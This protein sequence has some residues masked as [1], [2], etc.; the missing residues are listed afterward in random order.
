MS[1][2]PQSD[3]LQVGVDVTEL[4]NLTPTDHHDLE[5]TETEVKNESTNPPHGNALT[6]DDQ[7][8]LLGLLIL[9]YFAFLIS[10][11]VLN[12]YRSFALLIMTLVVLAY[13]MYAH[14]RDRWGR[15][16]SQTYLK[17]CVRTVKPSWR[18][19]KWLVFL[20]ALLCIG[21]FLGL[22][23]AKQ[24]D[25]L[26]SIGGY[27]TI[28]LIC[29]VCSKHPGQ[30]RWR[31]VLWGLALQFCLGLFVLRTSVGFQAFNFLGQ[32][33]EGFIKFADEGSQFVF[34]DLPVLTSPSGNLTDLT[35]TRAYLVHNVAFQVMPTVVF[36]ATVTS[37]L[38]H[39]GWMQFVIHKLAWLMQ[40]TLGI[41]GPEAV[42]AAGSI[43]LGLQTNNA[44]TS[45]SLPLD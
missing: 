3:D 29:F 9:S 10:G 33:F 23:T 5:E 37:L 14:A 31:P 20:G 17:P 36:F 11:L 32:T 27:V 12:F 39:L 7:K 28:L 22:E 2:K 30:V 35:L 38:Y 19:L 4:S 21:L 16:I 6:Q 15:K 1:K 18:Y 24:P 42:S 34:G 8:A 25:Q 43:F 45:T 13:L 26:I 44:R 40:L 41:T